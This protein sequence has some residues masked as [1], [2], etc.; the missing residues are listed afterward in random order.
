MRTPIRFPDLAALVFDV[1]G[2]LSE[3]EEL[4]RRAFNETFAAFGLPWIWDRSLFRHLYKVTGSKERIAHFIRAHGGAL[5]I[6]EL[7]REFI[8]RL[9]REKTERYLALINSGAAVLRPGI[10]RLVD[11]ALSAGVRLAIATA[12]SAPNVNALLR[13]SFGARGPKLFE[14]TIAGDMVERKK[15][16]PD[17]FVAALTVLGA[18]ANVCLAIEDSD[19]GLHSASAAGMPVLITP[20]DYTDNQDFSGALAVIP[21]LDRAGDVIPS[22][23]G[24]VHIAGLQRLMRSR[25][26]HA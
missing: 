8:A 20:S 12:A 7:E 19:S 21:D 25:L 9:H 23:D 4:H 26:D 6:G 24:L 14:A 16:A 13:A 3:T 5:P 1:D 18:P 17:S 2:T 11:E 22:E 10:E 15:P